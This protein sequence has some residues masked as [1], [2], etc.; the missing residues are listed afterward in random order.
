MNELSVRVRNK[1]G[2]RGL[3]E[4]AAE[5]S[6]QFGTISPA[7][8]SRIEAGKQPDIETFTKLCKWLEV[9]P[10]TIL[11]I[12]KEN[13]QTLKQD[14]KVYAHFRADRATS[15]E[16]ATHLANMILAVQKQYQKN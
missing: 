2:N 14:D 11:G 5:I 6:K 9:D 10:N 15:P 13:S 8:L 3:R 7:T 16:T 4:V 12:K 1:R